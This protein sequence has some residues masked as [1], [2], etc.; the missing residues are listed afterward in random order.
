LLLLG[1]L[2]VSVALASEQADINYYAISG[3]TT[4]QLLASM[5]E[6]GPADN[7]G[8]RFH[9]Y[10]RWHVSWTYDASAQQDGC[11]IDKVDTEVSGTITL[12]EWTDASTADGALRARWLRYSQVLREHEEGHF[13][14]A[15]AAAADIRR[16]LGGFSSGQDCKAMYKEANRLAQ[17]I[18][19][20]HQQRERAYDRETQHGRTQGLVL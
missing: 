11:V 14:F 8:R 13:R 15:Q 12:P 16:Q 2:P 3:S 20:E 19:R 18:L 5:E 17:Q 10:T 6:K 1:L 9:G 7:T 4:K